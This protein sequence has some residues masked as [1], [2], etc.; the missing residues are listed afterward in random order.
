MQRRGGNGVPF[1][2]LIDHYDACAVSKSHQLVHPKKAKRVE[3]MATFQ[4]V[5][6]DLM[7]PFKRAARGGYEFL[8]KIIDQFT[9]CTKDQAF[10][11]LQ[12]FV[13]STVILFGSRIVT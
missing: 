3:I 7:G 13:S 5:Y 12:L 4:L 1:D 10:A 11:S 8:S 2:S 6:G 9:K